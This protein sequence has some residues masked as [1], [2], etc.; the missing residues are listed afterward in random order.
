M[1]I[2][3]KIFPLS[4]NSEVLSNA[5]ATEETSGRTRVRSIAAVGLTVA[6]VVFFTLYLGYWDA[7]GLKER[8]QKELAAAKEEAEAAGAELAEQTIRGRILWD[9]KYSDWEKTDRPFDTTWYGV[10]SGYNYAALIYLDK[11]FLADYDILFLKNPTYPYSQKEID[12]MVEFVENGGGIFMMG[13]H[14][15][16]FGTSIPLNSVARE[17]GFFF[18]HDVVF[19]LENKFEQFVSLPKLTRSPVVRD[20]DEFLFQVSC[21]IEPL[22]VVGPTRNAIITRGSWALPYLYASQNFYPPVEF[23][24][25]MTYGPLVQ[26]IT[27]TRG[28]GR[29]VGF[30]DSTMFSNM[31][32]NMSMFFPGKPEMILNSME[33]LNRENRHNRLNG[34]FLFFAIV[35]LVPALVLIVRKPVL[36]GSFVASVCIGSFAAAI[37]A[38]AIT[39]HTS[40]EREYSD[41]EMPVRGFVRN[42]ERDYS[43]F[44]AW[45]PRVGYFPSLKKTFDEALAEHPDILVMINPSRYTPA[46]RDFPIEQ[47]ERRFN[48][49]FMPS[50]KQYLVGGGK[51]LLMDDASNEQS[52]S[53]KILQEFGMR[54]ESGAARA[55][56]TQRQQLQTAMLLNPNGEPVCSVPVGLRIIGGEPLMTIRHAD[57]R[58]QAQQHVILARKKIGEGT[59][60]VMSASG[61]FANAK[62]LEAPAD[63]EN[64]Q[65]VAHWLGENYSAFALQF[66]ILRGLAGDAQPG[67]DETTLKTSGTPGDH[68]MAELLRLPAHLRQHGAAR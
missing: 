46:N 61:R 8:Q 30:T 20:V 56:E 45:V 40:F 34:V 5:F 36:G 51:L 48:E 16:V 35:C 28:K 24:T 32:S 10:E 17:F 18:R 50:L 59:L 41:Y 3:A 26:M 4:R 44:Y 25:D 42:R 11:K 33:W 57:A 62:M 14:T 19:D 68:L 37:T 9:E 47:D 53:N 1:L 23:R 6:G 43:T 65:H 38:A 31:V 49:K 66:A 2:Y 58:R 7:G 39:A 21:S 63:A 55:S 15:N 52:L 29:V 60:L 22:S 64:P 67:Y 54:L 12:D 27:S 13:E